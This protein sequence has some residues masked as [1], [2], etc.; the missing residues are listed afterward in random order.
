VFSEFSPSAYNRGSSTQNLTSVV[1]RVLQ[2]ISEFSEVNSEESIVSALK[3]PFKQ[4]LINALETARK[5]SAKLHRNASE[6]VRSFPS[7]HWNIALR[8]NNL[9]LFSGGFIP[10]HF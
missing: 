10:L 3:E 8:H 1:I 2:K 4:K 5:F 7:R 9:L 6:A